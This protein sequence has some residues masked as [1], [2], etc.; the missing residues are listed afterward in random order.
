MCYSLNTLN[1]DYVGIG[2]TIGAI[3]GDTRSSDYGSSRFHGFLHFFTAYWALRKPLNPS[4]RYLDCLDCFW[5]CNHSL[6]MC[7]VQVV[8]KN[9][10]PDIS[11]TLLIFNFSRGVHVGA[12]NARHKEHLPW[13]QALLTSRTQKALRQ[14]GL[15]GESQRSVKSL[16]RA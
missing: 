11:T 16:C 9:P 7:R 5:L 2:T 1:C 12:P 10:F 14:L 4:N 15:P 6:L 13:A 3:K 8:E